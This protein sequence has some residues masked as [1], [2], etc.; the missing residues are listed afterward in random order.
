MHPVSHLINNS[1]YQSTSRVDVQLQVFRLSAHANLSLHAAMAQLHRPHI[2][3]AFVL[4]SVVFNFASSFHVYC[5]RDVVLTRHE[6]ALLFC[7][8][9]LLLTSC[10][11]NSENE[12]HRRIWD[13]EPAYSDIFT[14]RI[15][16]ILFKGQ[17]VARAVYYRVHF[18]SGFMLWALILLCT[19]LFGLLWLLH[20]LSPTCFPSAFP[21]SPARR[22]LVVSAPKVSDTRRLLWL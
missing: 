19:D 8:I 10:P 7:W 2:R 14:F 5:D 13:S 6:Y 22:L 12:Y 9:S 15:D 4:F 16:M 3:V 1:A 17:S 18:A 11:I 20:R 21:F